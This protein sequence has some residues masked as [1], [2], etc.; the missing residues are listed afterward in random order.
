MTDQKKD[1]VVEKALFHEFK[2]MKLSET[3]RE[4]EE[5]N[6]DRINGASFSD[7]ESFDKKWNTVFGEPYFQRVTAV[8]AP[9]RKEAVHPRDCNYGLESKIVHKP[10]MKRLRVHGQ[11]QN[12]WEDVDAEVFTLRDDGYWRVIFPTKTDPNQTDA[13]HLATNGLSLKLQRNVE[14]ILSGPFL[15]NAD[16]T[17]YALV[18]QTPGKNMNKDVRVSL[19]PY[20]VLERVTEKDF[21]EF[22][23]HKLPGIEAGAVKAL[24]SL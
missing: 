17:T 5:K 9:A 7:R 12:V 15:A 11:I 2:A 1:P 21:V 23:K 4:Y 16:H 19:Y 24:K 6:R 10:K 3:L 14:V 13:V 8:A 22:K 18:S 20:S